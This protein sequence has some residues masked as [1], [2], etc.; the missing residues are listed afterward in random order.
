MLPVCFGKYKKTFLSNHWWAKP[1]QKLSSTNVLGR[2]TLDT[3]TKISPEYQPC[4]ATHYCRQKERDS[5]FPKNFAFFSQ[6]ARFVGHILL[7][8]RFCFLLC[9]VVFLK[10]KTSSFSTNYSKCIDDAMLPIVLYQFFFL[11]WK[12]PGN[13]CIS[14][15]SEDEWGGEQWAS[16]LFF[17]MKNITKANF[18]LAKGT[19]GYKKV[20]VCLSH[21][22]FL[23]INFKISQFSS[24]KKSCFSKNGLMASLPK[25]LCCFS[26]P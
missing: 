23:F 6:V 16:M 4:S 8:K 21:L 26:E 19:S 13:F 1:W 5:R 10:E 24:V 18:N 22:F 25:F 14:I 20:P 7:N 15:T 12:V 2:G 11:L 9:V 17:P 3:C